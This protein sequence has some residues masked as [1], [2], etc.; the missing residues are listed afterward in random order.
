MSRFL[1]CSTPFA[2]FQRFG[3]HSESILVAKNE[4]VLVFDYLSM[5]SDWIGHPASPNATGGNFLRTKLDHGFTMQIF[6]RKYHVKD[7]L[8]SAAPSGAV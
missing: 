4:R 3:I 5:I 6:I 7:P 1:G 2:R 8:D